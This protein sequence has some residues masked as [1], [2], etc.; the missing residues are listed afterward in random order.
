MT[1]DY[2]EKWETFQW[3]C[4]YEFIISYRAKAARE[5]NGSLVTNVDVMYQDGRQG[6]QKVTWLIFDLHLK[7]RHKVVR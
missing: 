4:E 7:S 5:E 1:R 3:Q 6:G 2:W